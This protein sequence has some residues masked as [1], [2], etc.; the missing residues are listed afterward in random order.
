MKQLIGSR[1]RRTCTTIGTT[2]LLTIVI[3]ATALSIASSVSSADPPASGTV[4]GAVVDIN[5][6][7]LPGVTVTLLSGGTTIAQ[8][9]TGP[10]GLFTLNATA[11]TYTLRL[12]KTG[13]DG[14]ESSVTV[15]ALQ[16][17]DI[18]TIVL[19]ATSYLWI[20]VLGAI[21]VGA[22]VVWWLMKRR[23]NIERAMKR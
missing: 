12:N 18:G 21:A 23:E 16:D 13:F 14:D 6:K 22:V 1:Q 17:N 7:S 20:P 10:D 11:G 4:S 3:L 5:N 2:L 15:S 9:T 19:Y 8:T